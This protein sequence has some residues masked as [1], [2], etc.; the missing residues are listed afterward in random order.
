M[1]VIFSQKANKKFVKHQKT[2]LWNLPPQANNYHRLIN[3]AVGVIPFKS[4]ASI[5]MKL[6]LHK[7][8]TK[9]PEHRSF[10]VYYCNGKLV[11]RTHLDDK[12]TTQ[13]VE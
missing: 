5:F 13:E 2:T 4:M 3:E 12:M 10:S 1:G 8:V 7:Q 6:G 9:I 11:K